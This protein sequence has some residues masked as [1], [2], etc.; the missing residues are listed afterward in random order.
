MRNIKKKDSEQ[1]IELCE[2][3]KKEIYQSNSMQTACKEME[4][5]YSKGWKII[6]KAEN[7]LGYSLMMVSGGLPPASPPSRSPS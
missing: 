6:K 1:W 4:M 5:S 7:Y 3:V 2:Y